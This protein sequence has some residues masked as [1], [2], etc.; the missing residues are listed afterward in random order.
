[1]KPTLIE[2]GDI[3][4]LIGTDEIRLV[5]CQLDKDSLLILM[6]PKFDFII[7]DKRTVQHLYGKFESP[8]LREE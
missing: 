8:D 3:T 7:Y 4:V 1:M 2:V 6:F 5:M